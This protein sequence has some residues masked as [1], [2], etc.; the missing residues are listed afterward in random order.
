MTVFCSLVINIGT[1]KKKSTKHKE[2]KKHMTQIDKESVTHKEAARRLEVSVSC[3]TILVSAHN[4]SS[5]G[6]IVRV[7]KQGFD[8]PIF[9]LDWLPQ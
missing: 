6:I 5:L 1:V 4:K 3:I 7:R 2:R 9:C 8:R